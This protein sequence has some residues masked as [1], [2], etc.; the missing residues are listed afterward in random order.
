M[1][2]SKLLFLDSFLIESLIVVVVIL[3]AVPHTTY[4]S[5]EGGGEKKHNRKRS[6]FD[7]VRW[8]GYITLHGDLTMD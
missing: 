6:D 3:L 5:T 4:R 1:Y 8:N 7:D 2:V